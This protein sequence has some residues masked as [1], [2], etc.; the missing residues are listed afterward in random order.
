MGVHRRTGGH[1]GAH[2]RGGNPQ[3]ERLYPKNGAE[4]V[5]ASCRPCPHP[6]ACVPP[7]AVCQQSEPGGDPR[8]HIRRIPGGDQG[9]AKRLCRPVG[10]ALRS[11]GK[12]GFANQHLAAG[13]R[14]RQ[15]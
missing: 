9:P 1:P 11:A 5:C 12:T 3:H 14:G 15:L 7:A 8:Q 10:A 13:C 6:G 2:G 4:W